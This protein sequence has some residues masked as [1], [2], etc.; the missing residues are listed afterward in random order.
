MEDR[1]WRLLNRELNSEIIISVQDGEAFVSTYKGNWPVVQYNNLVL[2]LASEFVG[3]RR[4][5]LDE[6]GQVP[7][8]FNDMLLKLNLAFKQVFGIKFPIE[9]ISFPMNVGDIV[10]PHINIQND[11]NISVVKSKINAFEIAIT[12]LKSQLNDQPQKEKK[13]RTRRKAVISD[14][15]TKLT[16]EQLLKIF[17]I[18]KRLRFF[19][20]DVDQKDFIEIFSGRPAKNPINWFGTIYS[21]NRF[22]QGINGKSLTK[23][24][25]GKW[26]VVS[27]LFVID[28]RTILPESVGNPG[29]GE[30]D[31]LDEL[32]Q[33][34]YD[35][36]EAEEL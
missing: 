36:N 12:F 34:I 10:V 29:I 13:L 24:T 2:D 16:A 26:E 5:E 1:F 4:R 25:D 9:G 33:L 6:F 32:E 21:L 7:S 35:F 28:G 31:R 14:F 23:I 18:G 8:S 27:K 3:E 22:I 30:N 19:Y 20:N 11:P 15:R 17:K